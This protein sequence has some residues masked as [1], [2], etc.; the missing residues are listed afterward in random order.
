MDEII[1]TIIMTIVLLISIH[2]ITK[3][4]LDILVSSLFLFSALCIIAYVGI[5][6]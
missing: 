5:G 1:L 4:N 3:F 2:Y 6:L